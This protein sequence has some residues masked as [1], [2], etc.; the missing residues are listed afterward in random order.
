[1]KFWLLL[2]SLL[3]FG[4]GVSVGSLL[5][6]DAGIGVVDGP[7]TQ[8]LMEPPYLI[9][10]EDI[11]DEL[12]LDASQRKSLDSLVATHYRNVK[13]IRESLQSL[14]LDLRTGINEVLSQ[15]QRTRFEE[16]QRTYRER[17][18]QQRVFHDLVNL[19]EELNLI[20]EQEMLV[21]QILY[22]AEREARQAMRDLR[23]RRADRGEVREAWESIHQK[24]DAR[25]EAV[26]DLDQ[27]QVYREKRD[28][29]KRWWSQQRERF[30]KNGERGKRRR[31][32]PPAR[33]SEDEE[34]EPQPPPESPPGE[35][36]APPPG[37]PLRQEPPGVC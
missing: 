30:K 25:M 17:E 1:M 7:P 27:A 16:I 29:E 8:K 23:E 18:I 28:R 32:S 15:E 34:I 31:H 36:Q 19:R 14:S 20:P 24:R 11:Y 35:A 13:D 3:V 4:A 10:S 5:F 33:R 9:T 37:A 21:Y 22:D 12:D 26:L 6:H 2:S